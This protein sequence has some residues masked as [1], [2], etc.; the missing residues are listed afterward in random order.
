LG[1]PHVF[2]MRSQISHALILLLKE[3]N[4]IKSD[5]K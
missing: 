3:R 5:K 4:S 1:T 2:E